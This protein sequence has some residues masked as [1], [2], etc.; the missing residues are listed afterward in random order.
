M[1]NKKRKF[2]GIFNDALR[3]ELNKFYGF[4]EDYTGSI[5]GYER[6]MPSVH[7]VFKVKEIIELPTKQ[8]ELVNL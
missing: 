8:V 7:K 4:P 5:K 6:V 3:K 2:H 1:S